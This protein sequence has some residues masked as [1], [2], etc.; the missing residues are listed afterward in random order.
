MAD[1]GGCRRRVV[2]QTLFFPQTYK[3]AYPYRCSLYK[4]L[5]N[6]NPRVFK[7]SV[8]STSETKVSAVGRAR[9]EHVE[10]T[11]WLSSRSG[12]NNGW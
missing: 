6:N 11:T 4:T 2:L 8:A 12:P 9:V 7:E 3:K 10:V 5:Y 1:A